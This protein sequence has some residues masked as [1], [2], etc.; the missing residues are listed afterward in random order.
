MRIGR[1]PLFFLGI[2]VV[3]LVMLVPTPRQFRWLNVAM[4][5]LSLFWFVLLAAEELTG[6]RLPGEGRRDSDLLPGSV[7][8]DH[9]GVPPPP[10]RREGDR[11]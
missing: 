7:A 11:R 10:P 4:A 5:V 9:P 2:A 6:T 8:A 3:F 1:R